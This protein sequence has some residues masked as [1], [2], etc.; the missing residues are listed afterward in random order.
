MTS[1][2]GSQTTE[3]GMAYLDSRLRQPNTCCATVLVDELDA[4]KF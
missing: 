1:E 3:A 2:K 4:G